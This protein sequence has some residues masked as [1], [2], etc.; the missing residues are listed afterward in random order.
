[1]PALLRSL[2]PGQGRASWRR[3]RSELV[4]RPAM[5][6]VGSTAVRASVLSL[7]GRRP[8]RAAPSGAASTRP[9][10]LT[11]TVDIRRHTTYVLLHASSFASTVAWLAAG[12]S[13]AMVVFT[14][15][16]VVTLPG[17]SGGPM[18]AATC[19][20]R[21]GGG[22]ASL[23][24][25]RRSRVTSLG[26]PSK[27]MLQPLVATDPAAPLTTDLVAPRAAA[28]QVRPSRR[29]R[30]CPADKMRPSHSRRNA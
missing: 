17:C 28:A 7:V 4:T 19:R 15:P 27:P 14:R 24:T 12:R 2:A 26:S 16:G 22:R 25:V 3:R 10:D 1:M 8:P 13:V 5:W 23:G 21:R 9:F 29:P 20:H 11:P 30:T 18:A 6:L